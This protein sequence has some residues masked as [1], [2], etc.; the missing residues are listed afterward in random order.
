M[1]KLKVCSKPVCKIRSEISVF[2][3]FSRG[4]TNK[5][6]R[7]FAAMAKALKNRVANES[8]QHF[9]EEK[10][11]TVGL[12]DRRFENVS[13]A[14]VAKVWALGRWLAGDWLS[15]P[16]RQASFNIH[17]PA[18]ALRIPRWLL[19]GEHPIYEFIITT[20]VLINCYQIYNDCTNIQ[21]YKFTG[22]TKVSSHA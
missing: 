17:P 1:E 4:L 18:L 11:M 16:R 20:L 12:R 22:W 10:M 21:L 7:C 14:K 15:A 6:Q 9:D 3:R 5:G 13:V 19:R 2:C 8:D